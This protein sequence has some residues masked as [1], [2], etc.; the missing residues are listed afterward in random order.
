LQENILNQEKLDLDRNAKY[1]K[2]EIEGLEQTLSRCQF[3]YKDPTPNFDRSKVKGLVANLI[4]IPKEHIDKANALEVCA[5]GK[6]YQVIVE[7]HD[8]G[9]QLLKS[10]ER[11]RITIIP[12][13][14][15]TSFK[16][17]AEVQFN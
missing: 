3:S 11:R 10:A 12:L 15:I 9:I 13:N 14:K 2:E 6:L 1:L 5:G 8:V 17:Q 7:T 4:S 16:V